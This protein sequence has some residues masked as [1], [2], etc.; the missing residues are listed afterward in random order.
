MTDFETD[1]KNAGI[2]LKVLKKILSDHNMQL[3]KIMVEAVGYDGEKD[4]VPVDEEGMF[5]CCTCSRYCTSGYAGRCKSCNNER[6]ALCARGGERHECEQGKDSD[7]Q[8]DGGDDDN[9]DD[10]RDDNADTE[11]S[12]ESESDK[13]R[14][15]KE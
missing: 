9:E 12:K 2:D 11:R 7:D 6:C 3:G 10:G 1:L 14:S 8:D 5:I 15:R 13:K 4:F